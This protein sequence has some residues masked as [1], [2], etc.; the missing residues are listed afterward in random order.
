M[1]KY[2]Q[3]RSASQNPYP[4]AQVCVVL[5][6]GHECVNSDHFIARSARQGDSQQDSLVDN[7]RIL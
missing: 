7:I 3:D 1:A 2:A 5:C 4:V 6:G